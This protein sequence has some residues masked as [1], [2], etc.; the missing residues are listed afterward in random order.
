MCNGICRDLNSDNNRCGTCTKVCNDYQK[1]ISG[2]CSPEC[3][4]G[5]Q[6]CDGPGS[7]CIDLKTDPNN[8]GSC[9]NVCNPGV[10]C[11]N[12]KCYSDCNYD[13]NLDSITT[14]RAFFSKYPQY[15]IPRAT[16][17]SN[18]D[19]NIRII[20]KGNTDSATAV[21]AFDNS[22][23]SFTWPVN[24]TAQNNTL[25]IP[26]TWLELANAKLITTFKLQTDP[27]NSTLLSTFSVIYCRTPGN[28]VHIYKIKGIFVA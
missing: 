7:S 11:I 28:G 10:A 15:A 5:Q 9:K 20:Y 6:L 8:C 17:E 16:I 23:T 18:P 22:T 25:S 4:T 21:L 12:S 26:D 27:I 24:Y 13:S 3:N 19:F 14:V 2:N 1:C